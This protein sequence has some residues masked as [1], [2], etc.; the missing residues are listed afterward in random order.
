MSKGNSRLLG[1][2]LKHRFK[3]FAAPFQN[4]ASAFF[5]LSQTLVGTLALRVLRAVRRSPG[6][7]FVE[8]LP[9]ARAI[10][11]VIIHFEFQYCA[12]PAKL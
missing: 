11:I 5:A 3:S 12:D 9:P 6:K 8:S 10:V 7:S 1:L 4:S 2:I